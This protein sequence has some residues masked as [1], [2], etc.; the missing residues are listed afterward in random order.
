M[1]R[2]PPWERVPRPAKHPHDASAD[3][4]RTAVLPVPCAPSPAA[5]G[6]GEGLAGGCDLR[7]HSVVLSCPWRCMPPAPHFL[8]VLFK[9]V[10]TYSWS[11]ALA[12][13]TV[14]MPPL[15]MLNWG[16]VRTG[17]GHREGHV[18]GSEQHHLPPGSFPRQPWGT[19]PCSLPS[20]AGS[21][22]V[23]CIFSGATPALT[24][25][26]LRT[27]SPKWEGRVW[28]MLGPR[29]AAEEQ[30]RGRCRWGLGDRLRCPPLHMQA[31]CLTGSRSHIKVAGAQAGAGGDQGCARHGDKTPGRTE[32]PPSAGSATVA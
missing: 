30:H 1:R 17:L 8:K 23:P 11:S 19:S 26:P 13:P 18:E 28:K 29:A 16:A 7:V 4:G 5:P 6:S 9:H 10:T 24:Q 25:E 3:A 21:A 20:R 15:Q 32:L 22:E 27:Q 31:R 12:V 14:R 2:A